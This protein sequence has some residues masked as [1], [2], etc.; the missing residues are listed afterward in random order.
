MDGQRDSQ[1]KSS[2]SYRERQIPYNIIQVWNF[3][4][5]DTNKTYLQNRNRFID[6]GKKKK[7]YGYQS[8]KGGG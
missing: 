5:N 4:L 1:T 8:G 2:K 7:T 6:I 3:F